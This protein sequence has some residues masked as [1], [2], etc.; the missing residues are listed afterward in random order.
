MTEK[1]ITE[2]R[3]Q[4]GFITLEDDFFDGEEEKS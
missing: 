2:L 4:A 3:T 1:E